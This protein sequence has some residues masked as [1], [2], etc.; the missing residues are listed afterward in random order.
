MTSLRMIL[1][2]FYSGPQA[3]FF[4]AEDRGYLRDAVI[5]FEDGP[6]TLWEPDYMLSES[7][8]IGATLFQPL[9]DTMP[10]YGIDGA[11]VKQDSPRHHRSSG[12]IFKTE[13]KDA[14]LK[15]LAQLDSRTVGVEP[16]LEFR[17]F[18]KNRIPVM[19][20]VLPLYVEG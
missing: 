2:T 17:W 13:G 9:E 14:F 4:L 3:W 19:T 1:N 8:L 18:D 16:H 15:S 11:D 12:Y 10:Q 6:A 5:D 20:A 7:H